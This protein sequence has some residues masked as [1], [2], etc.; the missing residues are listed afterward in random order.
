MLR[1][2]HQHAA[3]LQRHH[4]RR[5]LALGRVCPRVKLLTEHD[6]AGA[7][8]H[9]PEKSRVGAGEI[10]R[11]YNERDRTRQ[12]MQVV[13]EVAARDDP[14]PPVVA[15]E[16]VDLGAE[17]GGFGAAVVVDAPVVDTGAEVGQRV[18]NEGGDD[19]LE[20]SVGLGCRRNGFR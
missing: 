10:N 5:Q 7:G 3:V 11:E 9:E 18:A 17:N 19:R 4:H 16:R 15:L 2:R 12:C 14:R 8:R 6:A 13:G 20:P 1:P